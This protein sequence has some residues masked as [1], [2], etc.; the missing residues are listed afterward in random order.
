[1]RNEQ[2]AREQDANRYDSRWW[3]R[4]WIVTQQNEILWLEIRV[5]DTAL[6]V[7]KRQAS[8]R[9]S[10]HGLNQWEWQASVMVA[11]NPTQ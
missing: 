1:M 5:N 8:Q 10:R 6:V 4:T 7:Q 9:M 11:L 3:Q 2:S